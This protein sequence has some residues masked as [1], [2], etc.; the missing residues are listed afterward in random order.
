[1]DNDSTRDFTLAEVVPAAR[2]ADK[3]CALEDTPHFETF[4]HALEYSRRRLLSQSGVNCS[5]LECPKGP[6]D[7]IILNRESFPVL[8]GKRLSSV[9]TLPPYV[10]FDDHGEFAIDMEFHDGFAY[11][12]PCGVVLSDAGG[13]ATRPYETESRSGLHGPTRG[14]TLRC[15]SEVRSGLA[16][17]LP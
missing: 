8:S 16:N 5:E 11:D 2:K 7:G 15:R 14:D 3:S 13:T 4:L 1:M 12:R 9:D 6:V 10:K 17:A